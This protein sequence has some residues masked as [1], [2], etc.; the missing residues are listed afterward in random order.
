MGYTIR[1][2]ED[3][4]AVEALNTLIFPADDWDDSEANWLVR[5]ETGTL[6]GFCS[7][8]KVKGEETAFLSRAGL[9]PLARGAGLQRRMI[10]IRERWAIQQGVTNVITY[11]MPDNHS[12]L[13]SLIKK[14]YRI[15]NPA[16]RYA[17]DVQYL[18]KQIKEE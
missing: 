1:R 5:D 12:S 14:G 13:V 17:G 8:R 3:V 15:Y 18:I 7:A 4:R 2:T 16:W 11:V 9:F 6:V 10:S